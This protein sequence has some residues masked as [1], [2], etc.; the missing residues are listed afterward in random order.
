MKHVVYNVH[1]TTC[2]LRSLVHAKCSFRLV[3]IL[4]IFMGLGWWRYISK[5]NHINLGMHELACFIPVFMKMIL[6]ME[7]WKKMFIHCKK[8]RSLKRRKKCCLS[9]FFKW[10]EGWKLRKFPP[11]PK[12]RVVGIMKNIKPSKLGGGKK[13]NCSNVPVE[14][15]V[16]RKRIIHPLQRKK[17]INYRDK[18]LKNQSN[19]RVFFLGLH[20]DW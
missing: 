19:L 15:E 7:K 9:N 1:K 10:L 18:I 4:M 8:R 12:E 17:L 20:K 14:K 11:I 2:N 16:G 6:G 5:S 13:R 3:G